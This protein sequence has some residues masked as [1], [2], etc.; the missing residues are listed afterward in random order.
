MHDTTQ[1][2]KHEFKIDCV[3]RANYKLNTVIYKYVYAIRN[4]SKWI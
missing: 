2:Q 3:I 4:I 1:Q